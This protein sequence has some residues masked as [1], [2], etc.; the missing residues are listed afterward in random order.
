[1]RNT[2]PESLIRHQMR[3]PGRSLIYPASSVRAPAQARPLSLLRKQGSAPQFPSPPQPQGQRRA[4][5]HPCQLTGVR[6][7]LLRLKWSTEQTM[8]SLATPRAR[9]QFTD[10]LR[11]RLTVVATHVSTVIAQDTRIPLMGPLPL[12][13]LHPLRVD[14]LTPDAKIYRD[15]RHATHFS[16]TQP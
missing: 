8:Q 4:F 2:C 5:E 13:Q 3:K 14:S 10:R 11:Q 1:M 6:P 9:Q 16:N 15:P 12:R 7:F